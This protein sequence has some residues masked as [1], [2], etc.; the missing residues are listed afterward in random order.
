MTDRSQ[1]VAP[2]KGPV[3][4][5]PPNIERPTAEGPPPPGPIHQGPPPGA[6][7][8]PPGPIHRGPPP[9]VCICP[10][11]PGGPANVI[12]VD[13]NGGEPE[14][15][16]REQRPGSGPQQ[17]PRV[18]NPVPTQAQRDAPRPASFSDDL[19]KLIVMGYDRTKAEDSLL[20]AE[21]DLRRALALLRGQ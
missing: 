15:E 1:P 6:C 18:G 13:A 17:P 14:C 12:D 9:G 19:Q 5:P 3:V 10:P 2:P 4:C 21:F 7:V 11:H 16:V 20:A 8:C